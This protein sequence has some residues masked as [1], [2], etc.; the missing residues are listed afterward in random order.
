[1]DF[2][3]FTASGVRDY[4]GGKD[5]VETYFGFDSTHVFTGF[6]YHNSIN[7]AGQYD[8]FDL[9][10]WDHTIGD[11]FGPGGPGSPGVMSSTDL[12]VMDVLGWNPVAG[13]STGS[14]AISDASITEG[15]SGT[16]L[17]TFTVTRSGGTSAFDVNF[18]T[19]DGTATVSDNDYLASSGTLHFGANV[20]SQTISV[21]INGD[22]KPQANETFF[23]NLSGATNGASISDSQGVGTILN[24]DKFPGIAS[25]DFNGDGNSDILW[26]YVDGSVAEWQMNGSQVLASLGVAQPDNSYRFQDTGDLNGDGKSDIIFRH[27]SG[28]VVLWEMNSDQI[29]T[30]T[31]IFD[32]SNS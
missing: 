11:A 27:T 14:V 17:L 23:V 22:T 18:A 28:Q 5:G 9:A 10:D 6:Q 12:R 24:D 21:T 4:T 26:R 25:N 7:A 30:N 20:N 1:M 19:A 8:G 3:R 32:V 31:S 2:F 29:V 16:K 15:N 13:P